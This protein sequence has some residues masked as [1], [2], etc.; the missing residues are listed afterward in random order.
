MFRNYLKIAIRNLGKHKTV[1]FIN[2]CGLAIGITVCLLIGLFI[3]DELSYDRHHKDAGRIFRVVKDFGNND[4]SRI[5]DATTPPA[6]APAMQKEIPEIETT[7]RLM[8][9][10]G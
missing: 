4:G 10:W 6:I 2:I 1:S 5:P 3:Q 8:P 7:A 9:G